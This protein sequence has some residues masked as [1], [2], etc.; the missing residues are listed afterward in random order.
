MET[1]PYIAADGDT[2][3][4]LVYHYEVNGKTYKIATDYGIKR[5]PAGAEEREVH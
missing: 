2:L 3:Y 4:R 1:E 5:I